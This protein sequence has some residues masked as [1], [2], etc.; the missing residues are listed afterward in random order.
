MLIQ[1]SRGYAMR[2]TLSV[3]EVGRAVAALK[4]QRP[5]VAV[6]VDNCYGEFTET[7]EPTV[8]PPRGP[9]PRR[10]PG[11]LPPPRGVCGFLSC[12]V[13][14]PSPPGQA[15]GADL[16]MGSLIKNPGGTIVPCGG[17]VAGKAE[18]VVCAGSLF[19]P[20]SLCA[21]LSLCAVRRRDTVCEF[22]SEV[23]RLSHRCRRTPPRG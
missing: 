2:P 9:R 11:R 10:R 15:V 5:D 16:I 1:R 17:Y 14:R 18:Y 8:R 19:P 12:C 3:A 4:A 20:P 6:F 22:T 21:R 23:P 13:P 7:M